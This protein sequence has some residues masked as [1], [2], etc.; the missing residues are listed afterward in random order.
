MK[1]ELRNNGYLVQIQWNFSKFISIL[2]PERTNVQIQIVYLTLLRCSLVIYWPSTEPSVKRWTCVN[3]RKKS[4]NRWTYES[5]YAGAC[6]S[7]VSWD[8]NA[9][10]RTSLQTEGF[11]HSV[12]HGWATLAK[13]QKCCYGQEKNLGQY[14]SPSLSPLISYT[15]RNIT[16]WKIKCERFIFL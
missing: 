12:T 3:K 15:Q 5:I 10:V 4:G 2:Y 11:G 16:L 6:G 9:K 14:S 7:A 13:M 8:R 1:N